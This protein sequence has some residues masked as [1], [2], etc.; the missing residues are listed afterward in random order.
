MRVRDVTT[1]PA[2]ALRPRPPGPLAAA[3]PVARGPA[4][5]PVGDAEGRL[6][7]RRGALRV[8]AGPELVAGEVRS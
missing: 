5:A 4:G 8:A 7:A 6:P 1:G 2:V 3:R